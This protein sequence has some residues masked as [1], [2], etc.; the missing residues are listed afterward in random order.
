MK[1]K[2]FYIMAKLSSRIALYHSKQFDKWHRVFDFWRLKHREKVGVIM[3][4]KILNFIKEERI[5]AQEYRGEKL[6]ESDYVKANVAHGEIQ[7]LNKVEAF[8]QEVAKDGG[9]IPVEAELPKENGRY[10]CTVFHADSYTVWIM[11]FKNGEFV[12]PDDIEGLDYEVLA[13]QRIAPYQ[14]GE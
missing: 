14:K 5:K 6:K 2:V 11:R 4:E 9:W 1:R 8:V 3:I 13:W 7:T 10:L 12:R